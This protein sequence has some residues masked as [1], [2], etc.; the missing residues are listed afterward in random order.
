MFPFIWILNGSAVFIARLFGLEPASEH[1]I[2]HTEDELKIIVG[3]SYK[4]GEINQSEFRY[5]NKIFVF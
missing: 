5:V 2:A 3:E 1:E 4:S